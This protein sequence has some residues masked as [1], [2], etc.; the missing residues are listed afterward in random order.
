MNCL[1]EQ[2]TRSWERHGAYLLNNRRIFLSE[3]L[4][5]IQNMKC[6]GY[7]N[8]CSCSKPQKS[9]CGLLY[10]FFFLKKAL[11]ECRTG[12]CCLQGRLLYRSFAVGYRGIP[13]LE[14]SVLTRRRTS[15]PLVRLLA[16]ESLAS[17]LMWSCLLT[18]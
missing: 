11:P 10:L 3:L 18:F 4:R 15:F 5:D 1:S 16:Y 9:F 13:E 17:L 12:A 8:L 2:V 6:N 7:L 14:I